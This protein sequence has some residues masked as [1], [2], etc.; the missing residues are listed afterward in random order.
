MFDSNPAI[1]TSSGY[2]SQNFGRSTPIRGN[3]SESSSSKNNMMSLYQPVSSIINR[4]ASDRYHRNE[5]RSNTKVDAETPEDYLARFKSNHTSHNKHSGMRTSSV[6]TASSKKLHHQA[7]KSTSKNIPGYHS[8]NP[9][10]STVYA[11]NISDRSY[12][13]KGKTSS[14]GNNIAMANYSH[15]LQQ[16]MNPANKSGSQS[17]TIDLYYIKEAAKDHSSGQ[18]DVYADSSNWKGK[19]PGKEAAN[20]NGQSS[21]ALRMKNDNLV[22]LRHKKDALKTDV[23]NQQY[24]LGLVEMK[25]KEK[26]DNLAKLR[27]LMT[28]KVSELD[29]ARANME[30]NFWRKK[31]QLED[32]LEA[33]KASNEENFIKLKANIEGINRKNQEPVIS[34][35]RG[36]LEKEASPRNPSHPYQ[37]D[38]VRKD[39]PP[40]PATIVERKYSESDRDST[41]VQHNN[42][43]N[44]TQI[45][46]YQ[47]PER[48]HQ[49]AP[50]REP[51]EYK[52]SVNT[53]Q[54]IKILG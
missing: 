49:P 34:S 46:N 3:L 2:K 52:R 48:T 4:H 47:L 37:S 45:D 35:Y 26:K 36:Y 9:K 1:P 10:D 24:D 14:Y 16:N 12:F 17:K 22:A 11:T 32:Q 50:A 28:Q 5:H 13:T 29:N 15:Q 53:N 42:P 6:G 33:I 30:E 51:M 25:I 38:S 19:Y 20:G 31:E 43:S 41:Q 8:S 40:Y 21:G 23:K 39:T 44:I 7:H 18:S 54:N 27:G